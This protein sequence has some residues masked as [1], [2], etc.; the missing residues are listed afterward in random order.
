MRQSKLNVHGL[1]KIVIEEVA[2]KN[3]LKFWVIGASKG[4]KLMTSPEGIMFMTTKLINKTLQ[5]SNKDC[6]TTH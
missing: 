3:M 1:S 4:K 6:L 2:Y 5:S